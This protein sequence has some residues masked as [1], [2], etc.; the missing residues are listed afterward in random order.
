MTPMTDAIHTNVPLA[1]V[2]MGVSG[3]GKSSVGQAIADAYGQVFIEG[4][5]LHPPENVARMSAGILLTDE[6]RWPWLDRIAAAMR[7]ATENGQGAVFSCSA[8]KRAYR[9]HLRAACGGRLAFVYL[10]GSLAVLSKRMGERKGHFMPASLL[11]SQLLTLEPPTG[12]P[13][14]V[15][16]NIDDT[17][18]G[19]VQKALSGLATLSQQE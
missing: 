13:G 3:C 18:A 12:E 4:D 7:R 5:A 9:D 8:L 17:R 1:I 16:V 2:V 10:E 11:D 6:D 19:V 14:V 15:T